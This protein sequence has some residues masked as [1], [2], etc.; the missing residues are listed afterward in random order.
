MV[1]GESSFLDWREQTYPR[2]MQP[3][4]IYSS[5]A[6]G[7]NA[8]HFRTYQILCGDG[9]AARQALG[10]V[11]KN[12]GAHSSPRS[13]RTSGSKIAATMANYLY[14][15]PCDERIAAFGS[16]GRIAGH[17]LSISAP[18]DRQTRMLASVPVMPFGIPCI[19]PQIPSIPPYHNNAIW[20]FVQ[21]YWNPLRRQAKRRTSSAA[22]PCIDLARCGSVPDQSGKHGCGYR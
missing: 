12:R 2:W 4:D 8:V 14:G 5:Q 7:T 6:L 13:T 11:H 21:A 19:Y 9:Q 20:P 3:A 16:S 18:P 17:A 15:R 22:R 1:L 10:G